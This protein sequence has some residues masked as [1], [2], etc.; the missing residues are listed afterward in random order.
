M[1]PKLKHA[2]FF[3]GL[4]ALFAHE[5]DATVNREW[6]LLP[7]LQSLSEQVARA[8]FV[9]LHVPLFTLVVAG[10]ASERERVRQTTRLG[11]GAFLIIQAGLHLWFSGRP[12]YTFDS[13]VSRSL[14]FGGAVL[15][16]IYL[17]VSI[18]DFKR[19]A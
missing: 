4:G 2:V 13:V 3:L 7:V 18:R 6:A 10:V 19:I 14:I 16:A 9:L 5:L 11:V 1:S 15:G 17:L 8:T 12:D